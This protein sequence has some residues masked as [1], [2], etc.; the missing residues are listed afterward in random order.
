MKTL[1][2]QNNFLTINVLEDEMNGHL[3]DYWMD[4][5]VRPKQVIGT[6]QNLVTCDFSV[7]HNKKQPV[8]TRSSW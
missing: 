7:L 2:T 6:M 1:G 4:T 8:A 5:I 3:R